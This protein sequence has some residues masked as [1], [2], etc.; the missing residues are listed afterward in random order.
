MSQTLPPLTPNRSRFILF[1]VPFNRQL[2]FLP[3]PHPNR[4]LD[5]WDAYHVKMPNSNRNRGIKFGQLVSKWEWIEKALL[6]E[7]QSVEQL[8]K[9]IKS[10]SPLFGIQRF[11]VLREL[12]DTCEEEERNNLFN[13]IL[14]K[15]IGLA[16][17][18]PLIVTQSVPLL[19][20]RQN[21]TL[22]L[23]QEQIAC[24]LSNAFF[25]TFP[26]RSQHNDEYKNFQC[27]NFLRLYL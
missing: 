19:R 20:Q 17:R 6:T 22:F 15:M 3:K 2:G 23:S 7:F 26:R 11:D 14:P 5:K 18:L 8:E 24:L 21:A 12:F 16:L 13:E 27:F 25:C 1:N 10:Y 9:A 4:Y